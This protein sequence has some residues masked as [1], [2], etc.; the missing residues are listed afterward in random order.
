MGHDGSGLHCRENKT[1]QNELINIKPINNFPDNAIEDL[2]ILKKMKN[3]YITPS[4]II[5]ENIIGVVS[6]NQTKK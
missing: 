5:T 3:V 6:K 4:I 2:I 1:I